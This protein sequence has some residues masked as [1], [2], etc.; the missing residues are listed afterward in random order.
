MPVL[1]VP[2]WHWMKWLSQLKVTEPESVSSINL[3]KFD[4]NK[5]ANTI[6]AAQSSDF[7]RCDW[8]S[9]GRLCDPPDISFLKFVDVVAG[10]SL[11][12][13]SIAALP[14]YY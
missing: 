13:R 11:A 4:L 3:Q 14:A 5:P 9:C 12:I 6:Q 8:S 2:V 7:R 1:H 10:I